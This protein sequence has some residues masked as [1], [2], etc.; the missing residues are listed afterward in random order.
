ME[1]QEITITYIMNAGGNATGTLSLYAAKYHEEVFESVYDELSANVLTE[2]SYQ[3]GYVTGTVKG[4]KSGILFT[5]IPYD[6]GWKA[7]V[8]GIEK[9]ITV[10]CGSFIGVQ[11]DK[12]LTKLNLD[13]P[14]LGS[15]MV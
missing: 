5:S 1:G 12:M 14:L 10:V 11:L 3:D 4:G 9:D 2:V 13:I 7:Y 6:K 8:D 15:S